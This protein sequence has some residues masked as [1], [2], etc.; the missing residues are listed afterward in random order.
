MAA[1]TMSIGR[2]VHPATSSSSRT[3]T[4]GDVRREE[5]VRAGEMSQQVNVV[6]CKPGDP[7]LIPVIFVKVGGRTDSLGSSS[8]LHTSVGCTPTHICHVHTQYINT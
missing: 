3:H 2:T 6:M 1:G 8:D 5:T 7:S 4:D